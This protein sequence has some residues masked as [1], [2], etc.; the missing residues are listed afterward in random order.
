MTSIWIIILLA[1]Q[2][3]IRHN[4]SLVSISPL[5]SYTAA[6][7][8]HKLEQVVKSYRYVVTGM[9]C[10]SLR[11][12][13]L[14]RKNKR[15]VEKSNR[16]CLRTTFCTKVARTTHVRTSVV[17]ILV[18]LIYMNQLYIRTCILYLIYFYVRRLEIDFTASTFKAST[19]H[20]YRTAHFMI[21]AVRTKYPC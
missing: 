5:G 18:Y 11:W 21:H 12:A 17:D 8:N 7:V 15:P 1:P 3:P 4:Q 6:R 10:H 2:V 16:I 20:T 19:Q 14:Q 13:W 9:L